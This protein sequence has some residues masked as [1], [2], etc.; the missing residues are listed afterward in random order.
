MG[1]KSNIHA[2]S[3]DLMFNM[4]PPGHE[5]RP[6]CALG[7]QKWELGRFD[8]S[9][10]GL[11]KGKIEQGEEAYGLVKMRVARFMATFGESCREITTYHPNFARNRLLS[12]PSEAGVVDLPRPVEGS[13]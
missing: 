6:T 12:R 3:G 10:P 11:R 8:L 2:S 4:R 9:L 5:D 7:W 13:E 1:R